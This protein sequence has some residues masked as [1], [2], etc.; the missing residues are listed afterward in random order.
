MTAAWLQFERAVAALCQALAP[1]AKVT[2]DAIIP[3]VDTGEPR[4][5]DVWIETSVGGHFPLTLLVS[6]KCYR[7][8]LNVQQLDAFIGE[9]A[10][11]G[12]HKGVIYS[13]SGFTRSALAKA[14]IKGTSCCVLLANQ[15]A[16]PEVLVF[17]TFCLRE[18]LRLAVR[19]IAEGEADWAELLNA[20]GEVNGETMP[21]HMALA[22]LFAADTADLREALT[23]QIAPI[24]QCVITLQVSDAEQEIQLIVETGWKAYRARMEACLVN[25]SYSFTEKDFKGNLSSPAIDTWSAEPGPGWEPVALDD[26]GG[27]NTVRLYFFQDDIGPRLAEM[28]KPV[29]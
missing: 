8:R 16:I 18:Q 28:A 20:E 5:R 7:R 10:S 27:G 13:A 25:G 14:A 4:Q 11:S 29:A 12:A 1:E 6:C 26:I 9:L 23:T 15:P 22:Q 21:A 24:R 19:G 17:D 2:H 3:D